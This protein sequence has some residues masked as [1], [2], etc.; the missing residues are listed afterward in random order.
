MYYSILQRLF[1]KHGIRTPWLDNIEFSRISED[2]ANWLDRP[3]DKDI[4]GVLKSYNGDKASRM[5]FVI[6]MELSS[7][8][9]KAV[10]VA[11]MSRFMAGTSAKNLLMVSHLLFVD[12]TLIFCEAD[13]E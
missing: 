9:D 12:D 3:F 13:P 5:L 10:S 1:S 4:L 8:M 2:N 11:H 7:M 6:I